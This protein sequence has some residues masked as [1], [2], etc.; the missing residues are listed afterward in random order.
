MP[1]N[2]NFTLEE[3]LKQKEDLVAKLQEL[4]N[5]NVNLDEITDDKEIKEEIKSIK[6]D[7]KEVVEE[8]EEAKED[9]KEEANI[10]VKEEKKDEKDVLETKIVN[11]INNVKQ[12]KVLNKHKKD[13]EILV[14]NFNDYM[15]NLM[16]EYDDV[17]IITNKDL[18]DM[19]EEYKSLRTEFELEFSKILN[20]LP[21][22]VDFDKP[23][24][25]YIIKTFQDIETDLDTFKV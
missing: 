7:I 14:F 9:V 8:I 1:K 5:S 13:V 20:K 24:Y 16:D 21:Y 22:G 18:K 17:K 4:E 19:D 10:D 23:L 3:L 12:Q 6:E 11:I 15:N 2:M 25:D